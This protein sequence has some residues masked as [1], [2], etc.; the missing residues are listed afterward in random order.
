VSGLHVGGAGGLAQQGCPQARCVH[1]ECRAHPAAR[2]PPSPPGGAPRRRPPDEAAAALA[3]TASRAA[4]SC[5]AIFH[6]SPASSKL[7]GA[8]DYRELRRLLDVGRSKHKAEWTQH[9]ARVQ[10]TCRFPIYSA[11]FAWRPR[12]CPTAPPG[13]S[14][15]HTDCGRGPTQTA[16]ASLW[17]CGG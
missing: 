6:R 14:A 13:G 9:V 10:A 11:K 8:G 17:R 12:L 5:L 16:A 2:G 1:T 3:P 15:V 4:A 7:P